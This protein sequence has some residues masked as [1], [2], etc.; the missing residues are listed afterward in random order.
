MNRR[1][2]SLRH[3]EGGA[4]LPRLVE[5]PLEGGGSVI[6]DVTDTPSPTGG[7]VTRGF[8]PGNLTV[9]AGETLDGAF[10]RIQ[11]V[12]T[13]IVAKLREV[14]DAPDEI[15]VEF[16]VPAQRRLRRNRGEGLRRGQLQG[17]A[18]LDGRIAVGQ[19][20]CTPTTSSGFASSARPRGRTASTRRAE[21]RGWRELRAS[22]LAA[23][24]RE[25]RAQDGR[26]APSDPPGRV[27]ADAARGR[28]RGDASS[29]RC[30]DHASATSTAIR[31][32][33]P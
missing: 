2:R 3:E 7:E 1:T 32:R 21:R 13:A 9:E 27:A 16:G 4:E 6:V 26:R 24:A 33:S 30:S 19:R 15:Q 12:A 17:R 29:R 11:P 8:R 28:L 31:W 25:L 14:A 18:A 5:F 23:R 10:S 22:L 20:E